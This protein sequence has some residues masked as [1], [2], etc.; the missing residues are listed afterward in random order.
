MAKTLLVSINLFDFNQTVCVFDNTQMYKRFSVPMEELED[1]ICS[2][3]STE[4]NIEDINIEGQQDFIQTIG[5]E[6]LTRFNQN[7]SNMNVRIILN[8]KVFN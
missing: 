7:Y 5:N 2:L 1:A 6:L 4:N 8:G 3:V